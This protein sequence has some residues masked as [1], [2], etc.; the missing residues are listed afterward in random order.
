MSLQ[1]GRGGYGLPMT[2]PGNESG[3]YGTDPRT[4]DGNQ[5]DERQHQ[6]DLPIDDTELAAPRG[7]DDRQESLEEADRDL[8]ERKDGDDPQATY[9]PEDQPRSEPRKQPR[10]DS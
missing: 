2:T 1:V 5:H 7:Y 10:H 4:T 6:D 3:S 8:F 9:K